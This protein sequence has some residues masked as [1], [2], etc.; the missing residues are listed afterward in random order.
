[1]PN[2]WSNNYEPA[3]NTIKKALCNVPVMSYFDPNRKTK[4]IVD[5]STKTRLYNILTQLDPDLQQHQ[6]VCYVSRSTTP[7]EQR[8]SQIEIES[9]AIEFGVSK[10]HIYLYRLPQFTIIMDDKPLVL[11]Y[12][13]F[14][15]ELPPSIL[16]HR[17]R[18]HDY[19]CTHQYEPGGAANSTYYL[20]RHTRNKGKEINTLELETENFMIPLCRH[21][22]LLP[23][24]SKKYTRWRTTTNRCKCCHN[25]LWTDTS[26]CKINKPWYHTRTPSKNLPRQIT[27]H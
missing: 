4:P 24:P 15:R 6:F 2:S 22:F 9:S 3:F 21:A 19:N 8:Y 20:S 17:L 27:S 25:P 26:L 12:S 14:R 1:M 23:L 10:N 11:V 16:N 13:T 7:Q 18:I 5:R